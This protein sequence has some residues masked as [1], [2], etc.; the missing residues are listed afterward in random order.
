LAGRIP[1]NFAEPGVQ[2]LGQDLWGG[3]CLVALPKGEY[4]QKNASE[5]ANR[6]EHQKRLLQHSNLPC[7]SKKNAKAEVTLPFKSI[8]KKETWKRKKVLLRNR[9]LTICSAFETRKG[10]TK[11]VDSLHS[12]FYGFSRVGSSENEYTGGETHLSNKKRVT[13]G[14]LTEKLIQGEHLQIDWEGRRNRFRIRGWPHG[15]G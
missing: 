11:Q 13:K 14:T 7:Q 6:S 4:D 9:T 12:S 10:V 8:K 5:S 2:P 3:R 15:R 1:A